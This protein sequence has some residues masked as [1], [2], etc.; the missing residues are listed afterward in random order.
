ML[1]IGVFAQVSQ[2]SIKILRHYDEVGLLKPVFVD[3]YSGYRYYSLEQLP[4]AHRII[5]LKDLGFSL[6]QIA[7]L[8]NQKLPPERL[9]RILSRR[10]EELSRQVREDQARLVRVEARLKQIG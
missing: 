4:R 7:G 2:V 6:E 10:Q 5:A 3:D 8:L 1:K 9:R